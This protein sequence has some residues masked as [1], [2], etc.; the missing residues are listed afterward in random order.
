MLPT[1]RQVVAAVRESRLAGQAGGW[2]PPLPAP[3]RHLVIPGLPGAPGSRD[4]YIAVPGSGAAQI[5]IT[6]ITQRGSYQPTGGTGIDLLGGSVSDLP[7]PSLAGITGALS[8]TSS[9]PVLEQGVM[10]TNPAG[11]AGLTQLVL[12]AP[13][14]AA[15][16]RIVTATT[17]TPA[18]AAAGGQ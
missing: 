11:S 7:L 6:A 10:A 18:S 14:K 2:L 17:T 12:S 8:I 4:L 3:A 5:K 15:S 1:V 13:G 9:V 16:V